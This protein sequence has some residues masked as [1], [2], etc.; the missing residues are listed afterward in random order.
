MRGT[1]QYRGELPRVRIAHGRASFHRARATIKQ[2][3]LLFSD[4]LNRQ[5]YPRRIRNFSILFLTCLNDRPTVR[6]RS[7]DTIH[8]PTMSVAE[9]QSAVISI[10]TLP[11][12]DRLKVYHWAMAQMEPEAGY[13]AFEEAF[14]AGCYDRIIAETDQ[15]YERGEA[16]TSLA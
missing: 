16:L 13:A 5:Q 9:I 3:A 11:P 15:E 4:S 6:V 8:T 10:R 1:N 14:R 12:A 2:P 7:I